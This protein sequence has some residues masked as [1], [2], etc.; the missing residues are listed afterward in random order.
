MVIE[1]IKLTS[2][3]AE[4]FEFRFNYRLFSRLLKLAFF[5]PKSKITIAMAYWRLFVSFIEPLVLT[6]S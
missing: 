2:K 4:I 5:N 1:I 3:Q 6:G